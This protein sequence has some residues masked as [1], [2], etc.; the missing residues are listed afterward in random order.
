MD[1]TLIMKIL[2]KE[3]F[4][5]LEDTVY[6]L[7]EITDEIRDS[8]IFN[9]DIFNDVKFLDSTQYGLVSSLQ[10]IKDLIT[11][12]E[13]PNLISGYTNSKEY[14]KKYV[15][16]FSIYID[17]ILK[18]IKPIDEKSLTHNNNMVVDLILKY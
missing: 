5:K 11:K 15:T 13:D 16:S 1:R 10:V 8:L 12:L 6:N 14:L 17:G 2:G 3:D 7:R 18:S 4:V 9:P